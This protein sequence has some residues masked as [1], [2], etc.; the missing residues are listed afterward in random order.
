MRLTYFLV[1]VF[2]ISC[3]SPPLSTLEKVKAL[4]LN[5][6]DGHIET[7]YPAEYEDR[8]IANVNLLS[9]STG[10]FKENFGVDQ[11]FSIAVID[12]VHWEKVTSVPFGLPFVSGPPYVVCIPAGSENILSNTIAAAIDGYELNAQYG[13]T[14]KEIVDLFV[15]LIGFHELGHI[16][17]HSYGATFP[18]K[19]TFEFAA[20]Y[21][22]YFYLDQNFVKER[23]TWIDVSKIIIK[24]SK[25]QYTSLKDFEMK[26]TGVGIQNYAW[27]QV[28]FLLQAEKVYKIQGKAFLT[29]LKTHTWKSNSETE[30]LDEMEEIGSVLCSGL[31]S[32]SC[33]KLNK[34]NINSV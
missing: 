17:A 9:K 31:N 25:P 3:S 32:M 33:N 12:S 26:Y 14:N 30:Y 18:N 19:W 29:E 34:S 13:M 20:T 11:T 4:D 5:S 23:D 1:L 28:V 6:I 8:A 22:A 21:F 27:Y 2:C 16:Y 15:S 24:E 7:Y 10:F